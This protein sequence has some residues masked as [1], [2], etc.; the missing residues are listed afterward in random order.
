[1]LQQGVLLN[2]CY[3]EIP[4]S[5]VG[6]QYASMTMPLDKNFYSYIFLLMVN[7]I[8]LKL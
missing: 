5:C 8:R 3:G 4:G 6:W 2:V 1:M 7:Y